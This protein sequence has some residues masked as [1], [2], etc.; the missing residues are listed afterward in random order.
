MDESRISPSIHRRNVVFLSLIEV[1]WGVGLGLVHTQ[2]VVPAFLDELGASATFIAA[3]SVCWTVAFSLSQVFSG[4]FSERLAR[5]KP[6]VIIL[7][8]LSP[9]SWLAIFFVNR[10]FV[11]A[12]AGH[13]L[14]RW[15]VLVAM[16]PYGLL[17][18][19]LVPLYS[20][21]ISAIVKEEKRAHTFGTVFAVQNICGA[22]TIYFLAHLMT[23]RAF[24]ANYATLYLLGVVMI[25]AGNFALLPTREVVRPFKVVRRSLGEYLKGLCSLLKEKRHLRRYLFARVF[26]VAN[27]ALLFFFVKNAKVRFGLRGT[28]WARLFVVF[29][30]MGQAVGNQVF[31][32]LADKFG[33]RTAA[34]VGN[35]FAAGAAFVAALAPDVRA[36]L[37]AQA[38]VGFFLA[39]DWISHLNLLI[40]Y[41]P[42]ERR[43]HYIGLVNICVAPVLA[44]EMFVV[45]ALF[46]AYNSLL[47]PACIFVPVAMVGVL[48][49]AFFVPSA[50]RVN[51]VVEGAG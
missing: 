32:R 1:F 21:Y 18:G 48:L 13:A 38:M 7:H 36:F 19:T 26:L 34:V 6:V 40:G 29:L 12:S 4:Y 22:V 20:A 17:V 2:A 46:D 37:I 49:M 5:R 33:Y 14:G 42:V 31:G 44:V 27:L 10:F 23:G 30:L 25:T 8:F 28:D 9:I 24:P 15:T 43:A 51:D 50:R 11:T 45:G 39:A 47:V 16:I 41:A 35:T 3:A